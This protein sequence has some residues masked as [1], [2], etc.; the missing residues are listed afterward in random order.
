MWSLENQKKPHSELPYT[1]TYY[2]KNSSRK[3]NTLVCNVHALIVELNS[4]DGGVVDHVKDGT[5][6]RY[7]VVRI[8]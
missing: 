1:Q 2:S 7:A 6:F 8:D 3:V 5:L 4:H